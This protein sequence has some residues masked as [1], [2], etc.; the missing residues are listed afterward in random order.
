MDDEKKTTSYDLCFDRG[1]NHCSD[2]LK[3][4]FLNF[5]EGL[6]AILLTAADAVMTLNKS[7]VDTLVQIT[8]DRGGL[9]DN[10][11]ETYLSSEHQLSPNDKTLLLYI[12]NLFELIVWLLRRQATGLGTES[13]T[14]PR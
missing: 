13:N 6:D 3:A 12:T 10:I 7:D 8:A 11:R 5:V 14:P 4:L 9:M 2:N 1:S